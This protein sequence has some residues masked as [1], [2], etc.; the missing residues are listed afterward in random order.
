MKRL[1]ITSLLFLVLPFCHSC[2]EQYN[3]YISGEHFSYT[4]SPSKPVKGNSFMVT[5]NPDRYYVVDDSC[6]T[7]VKVGDAIY[8]KGIWKFDNSTC[9]LEIDKSMV[10]GDISIKVDANLGQY[11]I[12]VYPGEWD[13]NPKGNPFVVPIDHDPLTPT[14]IF[15]VNNAQNFNKNCVDIEPKVNFTITGDSTKSFN[16]N[17]DDFYQNYTIRL[18]NE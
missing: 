17:R 7:E 3:I 9:T 4:F 5:F 14:K 13:T 16:M 1:G 18:N 15:E 8:E 6:I 2:N 12:S 11:T 10:L